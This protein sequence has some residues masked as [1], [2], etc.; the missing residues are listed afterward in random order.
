MDGSCNA[1][2]DEV[3]DVE[4]AFAKRHT[5]SPGRFGK[6]VWGEESAQ[7]FEVLLTNV[8]PYFTPMF[9][10]E[11]AR[12]L[13]TFKLFLT[14]KLRQRGLSFVKPRLEPLGRARRRPWKKERRA[15]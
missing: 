1:E 6:D 11:H 14:N 3:D 10:H 15:S 13:L 8:V 2:P 9:I 7:G 5:R 12:V 4:R